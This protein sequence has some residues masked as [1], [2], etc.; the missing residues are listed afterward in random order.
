M[1][2]ESLKKVDLIKE[3]NRLKVYNDSLVAENITLKETLRSAVKKYDF[4]LDDS[5]LGI[6]KS[7][8]D[9]KFV[10]ANYKLAQLFGY[11]SAN[12]FIKQIENIS[13]EIYALPTTRH[14]I[15]EVIKNNPDIY[16]F[17]VEFRK[18]DGS[19]FFADIICK[20]ILVS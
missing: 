18:K 6:F 19:T 17:E 14:N 8:L 9:G 10:E 16:T 1:D 20:L 3:L 4:I 13:N 15:I 2:Y 11:D 12:D 5:P 7:T